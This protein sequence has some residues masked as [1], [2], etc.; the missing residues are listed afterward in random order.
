MPIF[1]K[2]IMKILITGGIGFIGTNAAIYFSK[3]TK[4]QLVLVDNFSRLNVEINAKFLAENFR[5]IKIIKANVGE[6]GK[7]KNELKRSDVVIHLAGQT[8]VTTSIK[9]PKKDFEN[10]LY[11]S[12]L[13][14]EYLRKKHPKVILLFS[15][16]NKVYG[17]LK[18]HRLKLDKK[19]KRYVEL[20]HPRGLNEKTNLDFISPYGCSKGTV[21]LYFLN[22]A[23]IFNL[24]TVVFRQSCIYGE[25]QLGVEDQGWVAH[26]SKQFL[27]KKKINIFGDGFQ[28]RDLLYVEDLIEAY[29][30][31]IFNISKTKGEVFNIGGGIKN[32]FSLLEVIKIL[33]NYFQYKVKI[34]FFP[35]RLGD[36]KFFV[37]NNN[38]IKKILDWQ[39]KT[40]FKTGLK[41]L[42]KWQKENLK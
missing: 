34:D 13:L 22:Y 40:Y 16:T 12:F 5:K 29:E 4:N 36:Q 31:A 14:L 19:N 42:I 6:I 1:G 26:F 21:D 17:D 3:N 23:R 28:V 10:N 41:K 8:A 24:N 25:H 18:N 15:S 38:K 20:C 33:E 9:N 39:P 32:S 37:S 35:T 27:F 30:K 2:E 7:F 11:Q